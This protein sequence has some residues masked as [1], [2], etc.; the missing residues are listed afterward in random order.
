MMSQTAAERIAE[1]TQTLRVAERV[2]SIQDPHCPALSLIRRTLKRDCVDLSY[3]GTHQVFDP[4]AYVR[5]M[6]R[7]ARTRAHN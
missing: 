6:R 2:L 4:V 1:L 7:A 3:T 5:S